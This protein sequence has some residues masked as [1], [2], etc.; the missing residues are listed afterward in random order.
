LAGG[1]RVIRVAVPYN[2][3]ETGGGR[4][5]GL[6][7]YF[8]GEVEV[9]ARRALLIRDSSL[10]QQSPPP[11]YRVLPARASALEQLGDLEELRGGL[12]RWVSRHARWKLL[13][14]LL[15]APEPRGGWEYAYA[16]RIVGGLGIEGSRPLGGA[17]LPLAVE[18]GA[19]KARV[20]VGGRPDKIYT[21]LLRVDARF[22][23]AVR[24]LSG[25]P[26]SRL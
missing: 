17:W 19:G 26:G 2:I 20:L 18:L 22:A 23:R 14:L 5:L 10:L 3:I 4:R 15:P 8:W 9:P 1:V 24:G 7:A 11:G 6:D 21:W 13:R 25:G 12:S 16:E